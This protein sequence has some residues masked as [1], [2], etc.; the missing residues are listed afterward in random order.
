MS[1]QLTNDNKW[2]G[3]L[4]GTGSG[5][6]GEKGERSMWDAGKDGG[7]ETGFSNWQE[8]GENNNVYLFFTYYRYVIFIHVLYNRNNK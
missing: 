5:N 3:G 8:G 2:G 6:L 1:Q 7:G 4:R